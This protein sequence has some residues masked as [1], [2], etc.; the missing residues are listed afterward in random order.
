MLL[1]EFQRL[2]VSEWIQIRAS[3]RTSFEPWL[4]NKFLQDDLGWIAANSGGVH[5]ETVSERRAV[6][7]P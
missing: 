1:P 5:Q 3:R 2:V 6:R 4:L 7:V